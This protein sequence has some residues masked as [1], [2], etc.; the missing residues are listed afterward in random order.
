MRG[1]LTAARTL[2]RRAV[3]DAKEREPLR[4]DLLVDAAEIE[5]MGGDPDI[6][7]ATARTALHREAAFGRRYHEARARTALV[8]G[9]VARR[10]PDDDQV[11][12][13]H[14][15]ELATLA[16]THGLGALAPGV[17]LLRAVLEALDGDV[18]GVPEAPDGDVGG[19]LLT[20]SFATGPEAMP[21]KTAYLRFLG[22]IKP[23]LWIVRR[24]GG[25]F[26]DDAEIARARAEC[27]LVIDTVANVLSSRHGRREIR[28]RSS[29]VDLVA[30]L[31]ERPGV[32]APAEDLYRGVWGASDYHPLRNRNTLYIAI[33]RA[34]RALAE[35]LPERE[36]IVRARN[37]WLVPADLEICL[38][39][40]E[41]TSTGRVEPTRSLHHL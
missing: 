19:D 35:L 22:A 11:A 8:A 18:E 3:E 1:D 12:R 34:R 33:N 17:T 27:D 31:A 28:N 41:P 37:G 39:K 13:R 24:D 23:R 14:L 38:V 4:T 25:R 15:D 2:V 36:V 40:R 6:V 26:G 30:W 16:T 9:L 21:G 29:I 20:T 7:I 32:P 5:T 10:A